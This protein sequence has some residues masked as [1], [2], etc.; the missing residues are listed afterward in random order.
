MSD[1][2]DTRPKA[3]TLNVAQ[4]TKWAWEGKIRI[5]HF[6]RSFVW[7]RA[8]VIRLFD[9]IVRGYPVGTLLFWR[10]PEPAETLQLGALRVAARDMSDA[11]LVV[12]GQQRIISL[13]NALHPEG[14]SD[15]RFRLSYD[16]R[17]KVFLPTGDGAD[18]T[19]IPLPVLFDL[20]EVLRWF[21]DYSEVREFVEE[22]SD[23]NQRIRQFELVS[24]EFA[25]ADPAVPLEIFSRLNTSGI[26][27]T[28]AEL[29]LALY[30]GNAGGRD[31]VPTLERIARDISDDLGFG[32][33]DNDTF[34]QSVLARRAPDV[35]RNTRDEFGEASRSF[36]EFPDE[37]RNT[38]NNEGGKA[39]RSVVRFLQNL[40]GVPHFAF[41][42]YKYPLVVLTR[43]FAHFPEI[44][45]RSLQLVRRWFWRTELVGPEIFPGGVPGAVGQL[46][47]A[48]RPGDLEGSIQR[49]LLLI[50]S[51][52]ARPPDLR[53]FRSA[54]AA[55][56]FVLCS[57]WS[58]EPRSLTTGESFSRADIAACLDEERGPIAAVQYVI[59]RD[60]VPGGFRPCAAN[61][62]LYPAAN[63]SELGPLEG[64]L[65][66]HDDLSL[67]DDQRTLSPGEWDRSLAS[68]SI[69][70]AMAKSIRR[71][72]VDDF[73]H[74]RQSALTN[75]LD[76]FIQQRCEWDFEDT[77]PLDWLVL[78]DEDETEEL[79]DDSS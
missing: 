74:A 37:D 59:S 75:Q 36:V 62:T 66:L 2:F 33:I 12:D 20:R 10:R 42:P 49:L 47:R 40:A 39:V 61:R 54:S 25:G 79:S 53:R 60:S 69:S 43:L 46:N 22:A 6:Q 70:P 68:H 73:L 29:A 17:N 23:I 9:S 11:L 58:L 71:G 50:P 13:A 78:D 30:E 8:D 45:E 14:Q 51:S 16:L 67:Q 3:T 7:S 35:F 1:G 64:L 32:V 26:S 24:Y 5:P 57:W 63:K 19:I 34:L 27:L 4:L 56:R 41:L 55:T 21:A 72:A 28:R 18:P 77:P 48:V 15:D 31:A 65:Y 38:A 52:A 44:D 76:V